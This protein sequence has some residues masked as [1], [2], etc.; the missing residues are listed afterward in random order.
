MRFPRDIDRKKREE[1]ERRV[2]ASLVAEA[3]TKF[4]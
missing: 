2:E 1:K 3:H 4:Q